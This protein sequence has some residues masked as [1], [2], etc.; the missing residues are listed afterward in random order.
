MPG[1]NASASIIIDGGTTDSRAILDTQTTDTNPAFKITGS[2]SI[3]DIYGGVDVSP[4]I[5]LP[6]NVKTSGE[7]ALAFDISDKGK[8]IFNN[9]ERGTGSTIK[10]ENSSKTINISS[11]GSAEINKTKIIFSKNSATGIYVDDGILTGNNLVIESES[12]SFSSKAIE[13]RNNSNA[14]LNNLAL[15]LTHAINALDVNTSH[16]TVNGLNVAQ[17]AGETSTL[18]STHGTSTANRASVTIKDANVIVTGTSGYAMINAGDYSDVKLEGGNYTLNGDGSEQTTT[19]GLYVSGVDNGLE[20]NNLTL[21]TTGK[22]VNAIDVRGKARLNHDV[23]TTAGDNAFALFADSVDT[24][25]QATLTASDMTINTTGTDSAAIVAIRAGEVNVSDSEIKT[26]GAGAY[27]LSANTGGI[28]NGQQITGTSVGV[29]A[30]LI[31]ADMGSSMTLL[32]S[33]L[34]ATGADANGISASFGNNVATVT[35]DNSQ[36]RSA[37]GSIDTAG[38]NLDVNVNNGSSL[39]SANNVLVNAQSYTDS[40]TSTRYNSTVRLTANNANLAGTVYADAGSTVN[41]FLNNNASWSGETLTANDINVDATSLW[42]LADD[43]TI[44]N[45]HSDGKTQFAHAGSDYSTLTINGNSTG[46]GSFFINTLLGDDS[47]PTDKIVITGNL[48]GQHSLLVNNTGGLGAVTSGNG[49]NVVVVNGTS[50]ADALKLDGRVVEGA[51][52]YLLYQGGSTDANDW[53]LRS[54]YDCSSAVDPDPAN[55]NVVPSPNPKPSVDDIAWREEV[56]GYIAAPVLNM[57]YGFD[58]L[59]TYHQRTGGD[60]LHK[61]GAWGR[62]VGQHN[63]YD[64]GR[65]SYDTDVWFVQFGTDLYYRKDEQNT[66]QTGGILFTM[67]TQSTDASDSA[68]GKHAALS[69]DTGNIDSDVYSLGGYYTMKFEDGSYIDTIGMTSWYRN[70]YDSISEAKQDGYGVALSVEAGKPFTLYNHV[71]LEPQVQV[72]YQYL[73]LGSFHDDVSNVS[74]ATGNNG[75]VRGGVR[76]FTDENPA[77]TPYLTLDA[78][79]T[80]GD[81]PE[82]QIANE[83]LHAD[84]GDGWWQSG[85][86]MAINF[87][88]HT[89]VYGE[90]RYQK[91]FDSDSDGYGGGIGIKAKF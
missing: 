17:T 13:L 69:V 68:R 84:I 55:S 27:L 66:E 64:G 38:A 79:T 7:E 76:L 9:V 15:N 75:E 44:N 19:T 16:L 14:E 6:S 49:I 60:V 59:G 8:L 57:R 80:L 48:E 40:A 73:N 85:A 43:A 21:T 71:K 91:G 11:G 86:G 65:F 61:D 54:C 67:G 51:Y 63:E 62:T 72:K 37:S 82:V 90:V 77:F 83:R 28:V 87:S 70:N 25:G 34:T 32:G 58:I 81:A 3:L 41:L 78:V 46:S 23:I 74:G 12:N 24:A 31:H 88:E 10:T 22:Y 20:A 47:S 45:L 4:F 89:S 50:A 33:Q 30:D 18:V 26:V 29:N 52:E 35:L 2:G 1:I 53:Y 36:L 5:D 42:M 56:P 39:Q